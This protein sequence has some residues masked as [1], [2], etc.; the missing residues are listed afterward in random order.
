MQASFVTALAAAL[1]ILLPLVTADAAASLGTWA[2]AL[3]YRPAQPAQT[4]NAQE[5][6]QVGSA[7]YC[8]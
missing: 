7:L 3:A 2:R 4:T 8:T 5:A 1:S 6:G